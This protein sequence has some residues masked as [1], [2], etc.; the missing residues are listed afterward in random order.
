MIRWAGLV[1][2]ESEFPF[3]GS[4]TSTFL[5]KPGEPEEGLRQARTATSDADGAGRQRGPLKRAM[6]RLQRDILNDPQVDNL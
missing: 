6:K 3:P 4:L 2:W 5:R 1:P